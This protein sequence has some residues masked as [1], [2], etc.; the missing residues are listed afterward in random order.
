VLV[1]I[2]HLCPTSTPCPYLFQLAT[3]SIKPDGCCVVQDYRKLISPLSLR[4]LPGIGHHLEEKLNESGLSTVQQVWDLGDRA[5]RVLEGILGVATGKK[6]HYFCRGID[7]RPVV[8]SERKSIG[9]E[10]SYGVRFDG[11]YG[12][13]YM[14]SCL[15]VEVVKRMN[16]IGV[17]GGSKVTLKIKRRKQHAKAPMKFLGHGSCDNLSRSCDV[18][19]SATTADSKVLSNLCFTLYRQLGVPKED[20][21]GMGIVLT[22]LTF[23]VAGASAPSDA[24]CKQPDLRSWLC[25]RSAKEHAASDSSSAAVSTSDG[26]HGPVSLAHTATT[27]YNGQTNNEL[28]I[29]ASGQEA[30]SDCIEVDPG[31]EVPSLSQIRLSQVEFLTSPMKRW[32]LSILEAGTAPVGADS[33]PLPAPKKRKL[34]QPTLAPLKSHATAAKRSRFDANRRLVKSGRR[35]PASKAKGPKM[36]QSNR[37]YAVDSKSLFEDD[38]YPLSLFMDE[39]PSADADSLNRVTAFLLVCVNERRLGDLVVLLRS[40][41]NRTDRWGDD[42]VLQPITDQVNDAVE[43]IEGSRLDMNWI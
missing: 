5:L 6:I 9:A 11:E 30:E 33:R 19:A 10:C 23:S 13:D 1:V 27:A 16:A 17:R 35:G 20:V 31:F 26:V 42:R 24:S 32:V 41:R 40:I 8:A 25:T 43:A 37:C 22:K 34:I 39:N 18:P 14:I 28:S 12:P 36:R 15:A 4:Q 3:D 38:V 2:H 7:D 21:R 29:I